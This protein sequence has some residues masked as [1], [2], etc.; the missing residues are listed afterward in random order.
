[1]DEK[2]ILRIGRVEDKIKLYEPLLISLQK[3]MLISDEMS[4]IYKEIRV[5]KDSRIEVKGKLDTLFKTQ[6]RV[7]KEIIEKLESKDITQRL[8]KVEQNTKD[9]VSLEVRLKTAEDT[10]E[11]FKLKGWDLL[12]RIVPWIIAASTTMYAVL[13]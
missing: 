11:S 3:L 7:Y 6:D 5:L 8:N 12:L 10:I 1:M 2:A 4:E 9:A 13:R